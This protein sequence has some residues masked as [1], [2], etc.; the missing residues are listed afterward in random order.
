[1]IY[2][3]G[4][5]L[6][7]LLITIT[8]VLIG[9]SGV[10]VAIQ[11][12]ITTIDYS[13]SRLVAALLAQEGVEIVKNIRDTNLLEGD[14]WDE[15]LQPNGCYEVDYGDPVDLDPNI[16]F[17]PVCNYSTLAFLK[18]QENDF[19]NYNLGQETIYKRV[20]EINKISSE[21]IRLTVTVYWR[22]RDGGH[23]NFTVVQDMYK[24][25]E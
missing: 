17:S 24:W 2:N 1:M 25:W 15:G 5:T 12:S 7:E 14:N 20:V 21:K 18:K 10:F 23:Q 8:V 9:I 3:K 6:I 11:Q 4:F 19:Y 22:E 16:N 13:R